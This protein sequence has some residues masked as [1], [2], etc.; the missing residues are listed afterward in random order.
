MNTIEVRAWAKLNLSLDVLGK[1][2]DGYHAMRMV[3]QSVTLCDDLRVSLTEK[4]EFTADTN[5]R[6]LP[7]DERNIAAKAGKVFLEKIHERRHGVHVE[8]TKRVP[9]CAGLGGGSGDAAAVL[10]AMNELTS[11]HLPGAELEALA[12]LVGA[13]VPFCVAGGTALAEGRGERLTQLPPIPDCAIVI[14]KP[15]FSVSTP[16]LFAKLNC[17][18]LR[19]H[20]DTDGIIQAIREGSLLNLS[21]RVYNVFEDV[22]PRGSG[23]VCALKGALLD[24]GALGVAM[25]G[26]GPSV[27]GLFAEKAAAEAA[28]ERLRGKVRDCFL[29]APMRKIEIDK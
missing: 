19:C 21:R 14:V 23:E 7:G 6:Y 24:S 4:R 25:S 20:P 28:A 22:L 18:A 10:R 29:C 11:A 1:L 16:D 9:V 15:E 27:F 2:T 5:L 3:M 17:A 13:D 12:L 26:T 8:I